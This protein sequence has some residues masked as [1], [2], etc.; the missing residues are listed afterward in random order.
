MKLVFATVTNFASYKQLSFD[1][2]NQGL[3]LVSGPTGSGKSTLCDI[4]PWILFGVTSKGGAVDEVRS[5]NTTGPTEGVITCLVDDKRLQITRTR[6][7]AKE[8]DLV[9]LLDGEERR[10]KDIPDTQKLINQLLGMDADLY[11]AGAY[12]HEF[13]QT[14]QFF[15]ANAKTRRQITEQMADLSLAKLISE[16]TATKKKAV[17]AAIDSNSNTI[18]EHSGKVAYMEKYL[19]A[20][21]NQKL[22]WWTKQA[23]LIAKYTDLYDNFELNKAQNIAKLVRAYTNAEITCDYD[24][25]QLKAA[26]LPDEHFTSAYERIDASLSFCQDSKCTECGAPKD[27]QKRMLLNKQRYAVD[28]EKAKND[29]VKINIVQREQTLESKRTQY[30]SDLE[31]ENTSIN[32]YAEQ[33]KELKAAKNPHKIKDLLSDLAEAKAVLGSLQKA[34][35]ALVIELSDLDLLTKVNDTFRTKC[36]TNVTCTLQVFANKLLSTYF[37]S[38]IQVKFEADDKDRLEVLIA[39]DGNTCT[40]SQLSK[41]QRGL[42][43]LCFSVAVMQTIANHNGLSFSAV[44]F[45]EVL[46]GMDDELKRKAYRLLESLESKYESIFVIDHSEGFKTSFANQYNVRLVSGDSA[47]EKS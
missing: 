6:G 18:A 42:L 22:N 9:I 37:D 45:D 23:E 3:T 1:F 5:W 14:A 43:K 7:T 20:E 46:S 47:I 2:S 21:E 13:S 15:T 26:L 17:K 31:R 36:I 29:Q 28:T 44:Y 27:V 4:V 41:G 19:A 16:E 8:N 34:Q 12:F 33:L 35:N 38:E 32:T 30:H 24:L 39:K 11:L 10:G 40:Y 25:S